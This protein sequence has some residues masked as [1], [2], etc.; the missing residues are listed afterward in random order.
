MLHTVEST[1]PIE[2]IIE[3]LQK[4][5]TDNQFG[6]LEIIDLQA[7]LQEKGLDFD[8]PCRIVEICNPHQA[9]KILEEIPEVSTVLPCRIS[10]Y[11][12]KDKII[13]ATLKPTAMIR[14]FTQEKMQQLAQ[15]V[16]DTIIKIMEDSAR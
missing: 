10:I 11:V 7:K 2:Q 15:E 6:V 12:E 1:K 5:A 9:K 14:L 16:E 3:D 4:S 8:R 13:L